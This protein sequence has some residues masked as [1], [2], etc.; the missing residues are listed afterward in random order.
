MFL[1]AHNR[2]EDAEDANA[3]QP[4]ARDFAQSLAESYSL[5]ALVAHSRTVNGLRLNACALGVFHEGLWAVIDLAWS[6]LVDALEIAA[7]PPARG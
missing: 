6:I 3:T 2:S 1:D 5:L 4:P 7:R